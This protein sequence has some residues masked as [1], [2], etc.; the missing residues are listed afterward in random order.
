[1]MESPWWPIE[2]ME[3]PWWVRGPVPL[4]CFGGVKKK[5]TNVSVIVGR[6]TILRH[7]LRRL[8]RC[9]ILLAA[10]I[11]VDS[12]VLAYKY[13]SSAVYLRTRDTYLMCVFMC[14]ILQRVGKLLYSSRVSTPPLQFIPTLPLQQQLTQLLPGAWARQ[15]YLVAQGA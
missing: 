2:S 3:S 11:I 13:T 7:I 15:P 12:S 10:C 9:I 6:V 1:M 8:G 4:C 5:G 14:V